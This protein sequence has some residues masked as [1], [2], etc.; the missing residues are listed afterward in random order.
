M[1]VTVVVTDE[2]PKK[3]GLSSGPGFSALLENDLTVL[4]DTG[5]DPRLLTS[6]LNA[7]GYSPEDIDVVVISHNHWDHTGGLDAV[8]GKAAKVVTPERLGVPN[9]LV[10]GE[11]LGVGDVVLTDVLVGPPRERA[12]FVDG[13]LI[14]GC[15]HPG[16]DRFVE[17]CVGRGLEVEAVMGGFHMMGSPE[18]HVRA[19]AE[20]LR[21]LGVKVAGPCHCSGEVAKR[22]FS[23]Y[24]ETFEVGPGTV[25]RLG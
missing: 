11:W 2:P 18:S 21:E 5:P 4:F 14:T 22:V 10:R 24:F 15:A 9:E 8:A 25:V 3:E 16:I 6:N 20:R 7:L 1:R 23:E 17:W 13:L 19:V 12:V